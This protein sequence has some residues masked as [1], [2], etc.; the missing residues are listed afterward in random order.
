MNELCKS[1]PAV[2]SLWVLIFFCAVPLFYFCNK[3]VKIINIGTPEI[4][5]IIILKFEQAGITGEQIR[6]VFEDNLGIIFVSS[7]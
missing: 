1:I 7:P 3:T 6:R 4:I 2:T 5:A